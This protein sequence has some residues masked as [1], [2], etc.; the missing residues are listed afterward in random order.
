MVLHIILFA[1]NI[2]A[3]LEKY[4]FEEAIKELE[5]Y[6]LEQA[7]V[8]LMTTQKYLFAARQYMFKVSYKNVH[9]QAKHAQSQQ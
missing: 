6:H 5:K 1:G 3:A 7:Q 4:L 2:T 9:K 8:S